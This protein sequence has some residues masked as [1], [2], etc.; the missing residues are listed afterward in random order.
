MNELAGLQD[1]DR[2]LVAKAMELG[3]IGERAAAAY[4][5]V[6]TW[7]GRNPNLRP[8][9]VAKPRSPAP[10]RSN[11]VILNLGGDSDSEDDGFDPFEGPSR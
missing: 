7:N 4:A 9:S 10:A 11:Q 6:A 3:E 8:S 5:D 1:H 2:Q